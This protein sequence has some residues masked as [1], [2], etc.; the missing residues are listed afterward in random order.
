MTVTTEPGA[1]FSLPADLAEMA[2]VQ[3]WF[4]AQ[5]RH[6]NRAQGEAEANRKLGVLRDFCETTQIDPDGLVKSLFRD[7]PEGPRIK[8]KRRRIVVE[9]I[10]EFEAKARE[11]AD[12]R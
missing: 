2:T 3:H 10:A 9:Q 12:V 8:L 7:T 5:A 6:W 4:E 11:T 1:G